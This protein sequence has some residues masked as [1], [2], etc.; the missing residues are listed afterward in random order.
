V[1]LPLDLASLRHAFRIDSV[2]PVDV[3]DMALARIASD[4]V[5]GIW[6]QL[7]D[8][9]DVRAEAR[10]L[11]EDGAPDR[12][13][14]YG[15]PFAVKDNIDVA[16]IPTT[17]ACADYAYVPRRSATVVDR[18]RA[19]GALL[20]GKVNLDQF[21]TG[22][23]GVRSPYGVPPNPFDPAYV[24]GGSS[25]GSAA[26]VARGQVSFALATDTA[27]S[28][29]VPAAFNNLVGFKPS[30]GLF[31]TRGLVPACRS[32]DC[33]TLMTLTCEDARDIAEVA[34][35]Y[36]SDD[37]FSRPEASR[38]VWAMPRIPAGR[39]LAVPRAEDL[40]HCEDPAQTSFAVACD[41]LERLG[42]TLDR[43]D[44]A[45]FFEAG[46]VLYGGP[47]VSERLAGLES[48]VRE[49]PES[50]LPVVRTILEEGRRYSAVDAFRAIERLATLKRVVEPLW[51]RFDALV[52]PTAPMHPRIDEVESDPIGLNTRLGRYTTFANLL[53]LAAVAVPT[54][55]R[56]DGLPSGVT[57]LGPWGRDAVLL[58]LASSLHRRVDARLGATEWRIPP[59]SE[60]V[61]AR[62]PG[63]LPIAV[64][65]AHL[66]GQ[67]LNRELTDRGAYL[68][69]AAK[70]SRSYRLYALAGTKPPKPG[71]V[72]VSRGEGAAIAIEIW[73]L[74]QESVGSFLRGV[75]PPL[76]IGT[77]ETED[78]QL[79]HGF[80]CEPAATQGGRDI[81]EFGGWL[82]Y[83]QAR[84]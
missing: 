80:L 77:V 71:L 36:D 75:G 6:I 22:L 21:A 47:W 14:L 54:G 31:S 64:V 3:V 48:F 29:R 23:V 10:A 20:L 51:G 66:S 68:E 78:G 70:T 59:P 61:P 8:A 35:A 41:R 63:Y 53:D 16:G 65:G 2:R 50:V 40:A 25:S 27:G 18:L 13:P 12:M 76:A 38:H 81:T 72:R 32:I 83:L 82:G 55:F 43:V 33:M 37:A 74:P 58:S 7:R 39:R 17:V 62:P 57:L 11:A 9:E 30:R 49:H 56:E 84:E 46:H 67:P 19:A 15:V 42:F 5:P 52:V 73:A 44:M 1:S 28:A 24:T 34:C 4:A 60:P 69:R 79:V 45:P 26:A